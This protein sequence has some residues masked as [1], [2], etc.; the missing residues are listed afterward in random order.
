MVCY[1]HVVIHCCDGACRVL[2]FRLHGCKSCDSFIWLH[3]ENIPCAHCGD[4]NGRYKESG[5]PL[6]EVFYFPVLPRLESMYKS[7]EWRKAISYPEERPKRRD[8][9]LRSDIF[10]GTEYR[11]LRREVGDCENFLAL[12]Y[13]ADSIPADKRLKRSVLPGILR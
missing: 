7:A 2:C 6:E 1:I 11:R 9:R 13:C 12:G 4:Q 5:D 10:D 8:H 3:D